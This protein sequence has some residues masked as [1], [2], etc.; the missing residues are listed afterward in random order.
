M[1][2]DTIYQTKKAGDCSPAWIPP[3]TI[4]QSP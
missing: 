2:S 4:F 1:R 3:D